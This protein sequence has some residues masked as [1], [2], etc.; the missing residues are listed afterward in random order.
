MSEQIGKSPLHTSGKSQSEGAV[1]RLGR[2]VATWSIRWRWIV[3]AL[4]LA[5]TLAV[6]YGASNLKF[7]PD[8]RVF[9]GAQNPDFIANE[10]AQGTFGR[11]DNIAFVIIPKNGQVFTKDTLTAIH[12]LTEKAWG[13]QNVSR[14]DSV[15]NFQNT[16]GDGDNLIVED[17]VLDPSQLTPERLSQIRQ[18]VKSEPLLNGFVVSTDEKATIVNVVLQLPTDV[19]NITSQTKAAAR[20]IRDEV[21]A[22]HPDI[23]IHMSGVASLSAAFEE[24][25]LR[26]SATLIPAVYVLILIVMFVLI[27]SVFAV[28][29]SL[30]VIVVSTVVGMGAGGWLGIELTPISLSAPTIIL[31]VAVADAIHVLS[32]IRAKMLSGAERNVAIVDTMAL[33]FSPV[34]ITSLTTVVGFATL[35]FS[36]SPPFHHLGNIS[37]IGIGAAWLLSVTFLPA[38][39]SLVPLKFKTKKNQVA[40]TEAAQ[41]PLM[42]KI[43]NLVI[44]KPRVLL[45]STIALCLAAGAFIPSIKI[46]DQWSQYFGPN[47]EFRQAIDA[48]KQHFG[49]ETIEF[50]I[51][52]GTAGGVTDPKFLK[53]VDAFA[54]W[55]RTQDQTVSHVFSV[56][57]IMKRVS[58]N[59]NGDDPAFYKIPDDQALASQYML[60]YELSLPQGL[61]LND[62][63]DVDRR[64]TRLTATVYDI[65]TA[66]TRQ[67]LLDARAWFAAN[68]GGAKLEV[69]GAKILFSFVAERN[70]HS[71][72]QGAAWLVAAIF[73][74]VTLTFRSLSAGLLSVIANTL[75]IIATF[76]VWAILVG[77]VGFSVAA[78]GAVAVGLMVD[79]TVHFL[80]KYYHARKTDGA[81]VEEAIR[82]TFA[83]AGTAIFATTLILAAGFAIL[84]TSSFKLNADLG[85]MTGLAIVFAM[86]VNFLLLPA[87]FLILDQLKGGKMNAPPTPE[88]A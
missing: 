39:L 79:Y 35:N 58:R 7:A 50:V 30:L 13:L 42:D 53:T 76:G 48:T 27:R 70:I 1:A 28:V 11:P 49:T 67:F 82:Y 66:D 18:A 85:L 51:D 87:L 55:L 12:S 33:N 63:I 20:A 43:A 65:S 16:I 4:T 62:R 40:T 61:D 8:Y 86:L 17:L 23:V 19:P 6:G 52:P 9:F 75:P 31:T 34:F 14:V 36:D 80:S 26:D 78:V 2:S 73:L 71:M 32:G 59:M 15:T 38:F 54:Q 83:S 47:L 68:G 24:A 64:S 41:S 72:F 46:N 22:Q 56:S 44:A 69:T 29:G 81:T 45:G 57:D 3:M 25:G 88:M 74:I 21:L 37:A 77:T 84:V 60:V 5:I 10:K